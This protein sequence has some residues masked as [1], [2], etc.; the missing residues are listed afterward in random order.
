MRFGFVP[1]LLLRPERQ[2]Q[3]FH[4]QERNWKMTNRLRTVLACAA[5]VAAGLA[6]SNASAQT[7]PSAS[8]P[9][10]ASVPADPSAST[11]LQG[12]SVHSSDGNELGH[13]VEINRD[14]DGKLHS[15]QVDV[16][17]WLGVGSKIVTIGADKFEHM[18]DRVLLRLRAEEVR[19]MPETTQKPAGK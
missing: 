14:P 4:P 6:Y 13:V 5:C 9:T 8:A 1:I 19:L 7:N 15:I 3:R 11:E 12:K 10:K 17:R 16:G 18:K 2:S